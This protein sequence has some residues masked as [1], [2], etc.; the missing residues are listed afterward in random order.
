MEQ[1]EGSASNLTYLIDILQECG[2]TCCCVKGEEGDLLSVTFP[3]SGNSIEITTA[4][5]ILIMSSELPGY[6]DASKL[7]DRYFCLKFLDKG[8][9]TEIRAELDTFNEISVVKMLIRFETAIKT[10]GGLQ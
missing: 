4:H 1:I 7:N 2:L 5:D 10:E 8:D 3:D 9:Y 6:H